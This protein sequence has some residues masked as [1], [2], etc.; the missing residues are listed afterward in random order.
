MTALASRDSLPLN[1]VGQVYEFGSEAKFV[2]DLTE[3]SHNHVQHLKGLLSFL[4]TLRLKVIGPGRTCLK[5]S[6]PSINGEASSV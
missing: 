6:T 3:A 5:K 2:P 4:E 1:L